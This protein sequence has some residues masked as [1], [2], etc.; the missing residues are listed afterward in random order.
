MGLFDNLFGGP[1]YIE[2]DFN[3]AKSKID[4][5]AH[6]HFTR[7]IDYYNANQLLNA[8]QE[9][10]QC[11][12]IEP[13]NKNSYYYQGNFNEDMQDYKNAISSY[14][15]SLQLDPNQFWVN[16]R[17]GICYQCLNK[18]TEASKQFTIT[19][20]NFQEFID[21]IIGYEITIEQVYNNR[22]VCY[23]NL[24][25]SELCIDDCTNAIKS[26]SSYS[27][28]YI[29]RGLELIKLKRMSEAEADIKK[30]VSLGNTKANSI[31]AQYF[32]PKVKT[33]QKKPRIISEM[34][35]DIPESDVLTEQIIADIGNEEIN[36]ATQKMGALFTLIKSNP[37]MLAETNFPDKLGKVFVIM[38]N[39]KI[40]SVDDDIEA[41]ACIAYV[42]LSRAILQSPT[43]N[44][45][46]ER[47]LIMEFS[48]EQFNYSIQSALDVSDGGTI[49]F[50][51][52]EGQWG[53]TKARDGIFKM[54]I[55]DLYT[56]P[57]LYQQVD[58]FKRKKIE[59]DEMI[60]DNFFYNKTENDLIAEGEEHHKN[61]YDYFHNKIIVKHDI[62]V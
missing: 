58:I 60:A 4:V 47:L 27:N 6:V 13:K 11:I 28:S 30:A 56:N 33:V 52:P 40:S 5:K 34:K 14:E 62:S 59:F 32:T 53:G 12:L 23:A 41:I 48:R 29:V 26:N 24:K 22:A 35:S 16:F 25:K 15:T 19:I 20:R 50:F 38:L 10:K 18:N 17:L 7:A 39:N 36:F 44:L 61:A 51:S 3:G 9:I 55:A 54:E 42:L 46:L 21:P 2:F 8:L 49:N 43:P 57:V 45:Y 1:K 31:L 37:S